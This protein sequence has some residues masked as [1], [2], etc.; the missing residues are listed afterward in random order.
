MMKKRVDWID[1]YLT[2]N[3]RFHKTHILYRKVYVLNAILTIMLI[4]CLFF[5]VFDV[6]LFKM[7]KVAIV[8]AAAVFSPYYTLKKLTNINP[9]LTSR[10][11]FWLYA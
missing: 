3:N 2:N 7:Y 4:T 6:F 5:V 8:N 11:R 10:S 9:L 1:R